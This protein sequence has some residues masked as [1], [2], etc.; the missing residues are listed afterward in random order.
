MRSTGFK[1]D[2]IPQSALAPC[3]KRRGLSAEGTFQPWDGLGGRLGFVK[4][5][6]GKLAK[7]LGQVFLLCFARRWERVLSVSGRDGQP[8]RAEPLEGSGCGSLR[9]KAREKKK[10][11]KRKKEEEEER[12]WRSQAETSGEGSS[13]IRRR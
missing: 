12:Q 1:T 3:S 11:K 2:L 9:S 8:Q 13:W 6:Y 4:G 5:G 10:K 7:P